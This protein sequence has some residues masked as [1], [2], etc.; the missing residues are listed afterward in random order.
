MIVTVVRSDTMSSCAV[1]TGTLHA[2]FPEVHLGKI[3]LLA[4]YYIHLKAE[5]RWCSI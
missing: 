5:F 2:D 3:E 1:P 4:L